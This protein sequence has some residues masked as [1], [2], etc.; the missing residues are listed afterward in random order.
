[1]MREEA[2]PWELRAMETDPLTAARSDEFM[3]CIYQLGMLG[4]ATGAPTFRKMQERVLTQAATCTTSLPGS[5]C[6]VSTLSV[7][8]LV[9]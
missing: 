2:I 9:G 8:L 4:P 5:P 3:M 7:S 1:M 6:W